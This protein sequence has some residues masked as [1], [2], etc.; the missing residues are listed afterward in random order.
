MMAADELGQ[1]S[2]V[3]DISLPWTPST[4]PRKTHNKSR[5]SLFLSLKDKSSLNFLPQLKSRFS[6]S[7]RGSLSC[8]WLPNT[9][10]FI[11]DFIISS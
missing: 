1:L 11:T 4:K 10:P 7:I 9:I 8:E 3:M 6:S 5:S 2:R